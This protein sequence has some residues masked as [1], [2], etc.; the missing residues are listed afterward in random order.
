MSTD[1]QTA[2]VFLGARLR[3]LRTEAGLNGR[4]I[5]ARPNWQTS[6]VSRLKNGRS[7]IPSHATWKRGAEA[8]GQPDTAAKLKG[9]QKSLETRYR[10][11]RRQLTVGHRHGRKPEPQ[12]PSARR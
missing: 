6:K 4:K 3:E 7:R 12:R 5:A 2:R 8:V 10:T 11:W 1:F 9:R